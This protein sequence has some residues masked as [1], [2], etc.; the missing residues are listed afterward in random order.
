M[1]ELGYARSFRDLVAYQLAR[2][3]AQDIF[4]LN[5]NFPK[6]EAYALTDQVRRSSR[7]VGAQIAEA[8]AKRR[9]EKHFVSKLT[10]TDGEQ[11]ETQRWLETAVDCGYLTKE[12]A[13]LPIQKCERI[14]SLISS[15]INKSAAFGQPDPTTLR[16]ESAPYFTNHE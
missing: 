1:R 9:Y 4:D 3:C 12:Q 6:E 5:R 14:G 11:Q 7:S 10:D 2:E 8:W 13:R 16:E 15:M